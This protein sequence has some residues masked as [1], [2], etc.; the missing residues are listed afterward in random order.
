MATK[1]NKPISQE[2]REMYEWIGKK[3]QDRAEGREEVFSE[4]DLKPWGD[5][6]TVAEGKAMPNTNKDENQVQ[7][8]ADENNTA[9]IEEQQ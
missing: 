8:N 4:E 5:E 3:L 9:P 1:N 2:D 7:D 6:P